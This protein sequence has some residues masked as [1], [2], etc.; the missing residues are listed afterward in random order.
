MSAYKWLFNQPYVLL[1]L[2]ALFWGGNAVA[3]KLA[4][5]HISPFLLTTLRWIVAMAVIYP[6]ALPHLRREWPVIREKLLFLA[7][8]G[9]VGF[10][11]FNNLMYTALTHTSALNVAIIQ[12]SMPLSVFIFN[13]LL[14]GLRATF[15]QLA[16]FSLT[17]VGVLI[18]AARG[19]L[20]VL[21]G[22][23][24]NLG[25]LL[26]LIAISIYGIYSV[27]LKNKPD[28]HWL[29]FIAV[30]GTSAMFI[31]MVFSAWEISSGSVRWPD[32]QGWMVVL[33]TAIFPSILS[34]VFWMRGLEIIGANRGGVFI[35]IVP[36][37][38]SALAILILGENFRWYHAAALVLVI[39]GV[40]LSQRV[41]RTRKQ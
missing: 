36:I 7:I 38:G 12:A 33:Y 35:N 2:T 16:G 4:V 27:Y 1:V 20:T 15:L 8:L 39:G 22:L 29:S 9:C 17:L 6:F 13:F 19:D 23:D 30:L 11:I 41:A 31:S 24:F 10:T 25:D 40:W 14:F 21:T 34:Q 37:F 18:I 26:M 5:G 32:M 3:G 28:I